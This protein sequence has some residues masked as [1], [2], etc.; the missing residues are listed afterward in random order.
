MLQS[1]AFSTPLSTVPSPVPSTASPIKTILIINDNPEVVLNIREI[2]NSS[3]FKIYVTENSIDS[4]ALAKHI[5]PNIILCPCS[6]LLSNEHCLISLLRETEQTKKIPIVLLLENLNLHE[7]R[8]GFDLGADDYII[9]PFDAEEIYSVVDLRIKRH[10]QQTSQV[11]ICPTKDLQI[12]RK[13]DISQQKL[14]EVRQFNLIKSN[15]IGKISTDLR[16]PISNI[17]MAIRMLLQCDN[18]EEKSKYLTIL[19]SECVREIQILNEV[20]TLHSI[21]TLDNMEILNRFNLLGS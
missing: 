10:E 6:S 2:L 7:I 13:L 19:E 4:I 11:D 17:N 8:R 20:D 14:K 12:Q 1:T 21:L 18:S 16:D 9:Y 5:A 15:L 3:N